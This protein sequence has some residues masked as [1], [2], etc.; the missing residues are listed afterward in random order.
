MKHYD[1]TI[2]QLAIYLIGLFTLTLGISLSIYAGLGVSPV[3]SLAYAFTLATGI[4]VGLTTIIA[5]VLFIV[6]Q[7]IITREWNWRSYTAQFVITLFFG[8]FTDFTL[9]LV[10]AFLPIPETLPIRI[11][12]LIASL[13]VVA[14]GLLGYLS[15]RLPMMPYDALTYV[16]SDHFHM[17]FSKAKVTS[18][19]VNVTV[20]GIVCLI[21]VHHLGSIGIGTLIAALFIGKIL[22]VF[23]RKWQQPLVSWMMYSKFEKTT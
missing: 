5:N 1:R 12:Y 4:S 13:F 19:L 15:A 16:I 8:S 6:I 14:L 22:G 20:A 9:W 23:I 7:I 10:Q 21:T 2:K 18:D 17:A 11:L 3:S